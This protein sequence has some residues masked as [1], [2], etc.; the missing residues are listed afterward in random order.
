VKGQPD[1]PGLVYIGEGAVNIYT[2]WNPE[3]CDTTR[4][5]IRLRIVAPPVCR[6]LPSRIIG[7]EHASSGHHGHEVHDEAA[8]RSKVMSPDDVQ[9]GSLG[10]RQGSG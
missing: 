8:E 10:A 6:Q 7:L 2:C 3:V 1:Q 9:S 5:T 4:A